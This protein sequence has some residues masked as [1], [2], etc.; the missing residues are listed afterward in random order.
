MAPR[1]GA[2]YP[3]E[4]ETRSHPRAYYKSPE[5][6][7]LGLPAAPAIMVGDELLV[8]GS[9]IA[10]EELEC[11]ICRQL[12]LPEPE[13]GKEGILGRTFGRQPP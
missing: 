6:T 5:Y 10:E 1:L 2:K 12:G 7:G 4:M 13:P 9:D 8:E 3:V 11:M